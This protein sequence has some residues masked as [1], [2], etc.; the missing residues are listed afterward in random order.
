MNVLLRLLILALTVDSLVNAGDER[1][2][3]KALGP[4]NLIILFGFAMLFP[5]LHRVLKQWKTYP[6]WFDSLYLSIFFVD[7]PAIPPISTTGSN[8]ST[9][10]R[11]STGPVRWR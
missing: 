5:L 9:T 4:R 2:A 3:G 1:F 6:W 7:M 8:G 11:T 10:F